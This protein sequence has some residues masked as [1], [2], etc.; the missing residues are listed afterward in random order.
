MQVGPDLQGVTMRRERDWL[1][2]FIG[3]PN[4]VRSAKDPIALELAKQYQVRMPKV[5]LTGKE[6]Q[7]IIAYLEAADKALS[8]PRA[9]AAGAPQPALAHEHRHHDHR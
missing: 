7:D 1:L 9:L 6:L 8:K 3:A 4:L 5:E 2:H